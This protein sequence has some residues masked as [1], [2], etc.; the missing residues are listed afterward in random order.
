MTNSGKPVTIKS[1]AKELGISFSTVSKALNGN[2]SIKEE[3][4]IMVTEKAK[5]MGYTPNTLAKG[6]KGESTKTIAI[7]FNDIENAVLTFIF[8]TIAIDMAKYGYTTMI[9]DSQFNEATERANILTVLSRQVDFVILEPT[10]ENSDNLRLL[11]NMEN[12]LILYGANHETIPCHH[13]YVD[14]FLGGYL[15]ANEL[16]RKGHRECIILT[17][18][19]EFPSSSQFVAG[20]KSAFES[21]HLSFTNDRIFTPKA[22]IQDAYECMEELWNPE[23]SCYNIPFTGVLTFDDHSAY[24]VIKSAA[25]HQ[26]S[27]PEDISVIGYDD[28]PLS[29]FSNPPLT[30]IRLP[31]EKMAESCICILHSILLNKENKLCVYSLEPTLISRGSVKT[32]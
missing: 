19:L 24:G 28:N 4:R 15:S 16:L 21:H 31:K 22:T 9:F 5:E 13:V 32:L 6:L 30:T 20:I 26:L 29:E 23:E 17:A 2:P 3:T 18:S 12:K 7:I 14:Y 25:I 11:D 1:I 10:T 27:V 8:R